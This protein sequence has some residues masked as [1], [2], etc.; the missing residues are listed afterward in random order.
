MPA[1]TVHGSPGH[2][3]AAT[4]NSA[5]YSA[6]MSPTGPLGTGTGAGAEPDGG[7]GADGGAGTGAPDPAPAGVSATGA[8][9]ESGW[10]LADGGAAVTVDVV[11][12]SIYA[13]R[14]ATAVGPTGRGTI[15]TVVQTA[16]PLFT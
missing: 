14:K 11:C 15:R 7:A 13:T 6:G 9:S 3:A 5:T 10:S 4:W 1:S 2:V 12:P 16:R 8:G